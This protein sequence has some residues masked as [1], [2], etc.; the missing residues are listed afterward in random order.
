[1][2]GK[3]KKIKLY[4]ENAFLSNKMD[5]DLDN[6]SVSCIKYI[7]KMQYLAA[8]YYN[9]ALILWDTVLKE[10]RK[11]YNDQT[12]GIYQIEYNLT[13]NLIYT[14]GFD[15]DI[16]IYDPYVDFKCIHRL[17]GHRY[18]INS[19]ACINNDNDFVSI[20]IYGNIKIWDLSNFY[21][22]INSIACINNDNDF[23]SIDIYGN[24]KIWDL[25]NFYN[26]QSINLNETLNLI[27]IKN[28]QSQVKRKISSNQK[29]IYLP[30]VKKIFTF[31]EKLMIFGM[32]SAELTDLCDT[33][34]VL[35]CFYKP[36]KFSFYTICL[37]KIKV[38]NVFNGKLKYVF[39]DF[40]PNQN[41]EI[42]AFFTDKS[43]KKIYI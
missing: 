14:C 6:V 28:N 24:I 38:W 10:H 43:M 40:L 13:K 18:S 33:Q 23:V 1:M 12:T 7:D 25:S 31:G 22:S 16:Y 36:S 27:K 39:D 41:S 34:S 9:G 19:I 21:Y 35:G 8:A 11:F 2:Q 30:R 3:G 15:H 29:M 37:K 20:D 4:G 5:F 32:V 26:Y 42:T 17:K